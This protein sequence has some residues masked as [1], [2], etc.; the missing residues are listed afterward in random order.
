M[1]VWHVDH[2]RDAQIR[3]AR[4]SGKDITAEE[5]M[6]L[7]TERPIEDVPITIEID[8]D[9]KSKNLAEAKAAERR[10]EADRRV[11]Q[12][13]GSGFDTLLATHFPA[14]AISQAK[15]VMACE[16]GGNP[17][18][19]NINRNGTQDSG[20]FQINDVHLGRVGG[21]RSRLMDPA[22]NIK[23][24]ADIYKEQ[25]WRPWVCAKKLNIV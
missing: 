22:T 19:K 6:K 9:Q 20:L 25:G 8:P 13:T 24:A 17:S 11:S 18:A 12:A 15:I 21:D 16:S 23:V 14:K 3:K 1:S 7:L 10:Q 4:Q 2:M 5:L